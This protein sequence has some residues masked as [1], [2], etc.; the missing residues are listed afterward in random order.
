MIIEMRKIVNNVDLG[1]FGKKNLNVDVRFKF[2]KDEW[3]LYCS[4]IYIQ[5][6]DGKQ[7]PINDGLVSREWLTTIANECLNE[8]KSI[9]KWNFT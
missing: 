7:T 8:V 9:T 5:H 6:S 2:Q 1:T 4:F 3:Q